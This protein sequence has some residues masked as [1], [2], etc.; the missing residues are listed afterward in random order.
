MCAGLQ[1]GD[2][3]AANSKYRGYRIVGSVQRGKEA[4][5]RPMRQT[6]N[7]EGN[8]STR[9]NGLEYNSLFLLLQYN[10]PSYRSLLQ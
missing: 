9:Y 6:E 1:F 5:Y 10:I 8:L 3:G 7:Y 4:G 2:A